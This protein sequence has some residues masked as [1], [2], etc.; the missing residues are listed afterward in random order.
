V[1]FLPEGLLGRPLSDSPSTGLTLP[2]AR[3]RKG[4][5]DWTQ[6]GAAKRGVGKE[7]H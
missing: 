1:L 4:H 2:D 7:G 3:F 5:P 6:S